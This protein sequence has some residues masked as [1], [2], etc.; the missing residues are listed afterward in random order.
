[1]K[2]EIKKLDKTDFKYAYA[3]IKEWFRDEVDEIVKLPSDNHVQKLL[4]DPHFHIYVALIDGEV[5]GGLTAYEL[6]MFYKEENEIFLYEIGVNQEYRRMGIAESL[7]D[8]LKDYCVGVG[9]REI[10][11]IANT[12]NE[13]ARRLYEKSGAQLELAT[14][15]TMEV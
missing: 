14:M 10:F 13:G 7:I 1:M 2:Y 11:V 12:N 4:N 15:Y 8:H 5:I 9:V 3:L 6:T